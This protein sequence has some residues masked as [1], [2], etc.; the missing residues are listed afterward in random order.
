M[1]ALPFALLG[2]ALACSAQLTT[3]HE[4]GTGPHALYVLHA[5]GGA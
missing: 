2:L 3:I 4:V 1:R 5:S